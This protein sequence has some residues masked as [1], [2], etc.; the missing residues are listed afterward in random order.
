M[1]KKGETKI[2]WII[3]PECGSKI[4]LIVSI[5]KPT[6]ISEKQGPSE[7]SIVSSVESITEKLSTLGVD[8]SLIEIEERDDLIVITPRRF[9]GDLW[10][11]INEMLKTLGAVWIR[12]GKQSRWEIHK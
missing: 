8:L 7:I 2:N 3:C 4:G 5:G 11:Q 9:L 6:I 1:E 10:S 12:E